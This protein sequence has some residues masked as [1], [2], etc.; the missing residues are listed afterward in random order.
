MPA[1]RRKPWP[2]EAESL[3]QEAQDLSDEA[4]QLMHEASKLLRNGQP[5]EA[6]IKMSEARAYNERI[7]RLLSEAKHP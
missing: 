4:S 3:R 2:Y 7:A 6:Q 5:L 1:S